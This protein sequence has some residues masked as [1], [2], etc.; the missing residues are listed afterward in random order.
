LFPSLLSVTQPSADTVLKHRPYP[1]PTGQHE[2]SVFLTGLTLRG[3]LESTLAPAMTTRLWPRGGRCLA[4][5]YCTANWP[6]LQ[7]T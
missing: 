3:R 7:H 6:H 5:P 1:G 2:A 4:R